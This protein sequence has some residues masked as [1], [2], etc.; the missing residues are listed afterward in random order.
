MNFTPSF[1]CLSTDESCESVLRI[2]STLNLSTDCD[3]VDCGA[4]PE[5]ADDEADASCSAFVRRSS[6]LG[7]RSGS[8]DSLHKINRRTIMKPKRV[9][10]P[11]T[12]KEIE[13]YYLNKKVV[14]KCTPLETI[15]EE[16]KI[17][18]EQVS[19]LGN[20]KVN[21]SIKFTDGKNV[22]KASI[23]KRRKK[24]REVFG[25][26]QFKK[27]SMDYFLEHFNGV[28]PSKSTD[29][30]DPDDQKEQESS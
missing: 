5:V 22:T 18:K 8:K 30:D 25:K 14:T 28:A 20:R 27:I 17:V 19:F 4:S 3:D 23:Q 11:I 13:A 21:R 10:N 15:F 7:S 29:P 16:P 9:F 26:P 12:K 1:T 24:A 2:M 6:R